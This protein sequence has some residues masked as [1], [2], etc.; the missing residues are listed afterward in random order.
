MVI[1]LPQAMKLPVY[2]AGLPGKV[3][4]FIL[5]PPWSGL[6]DLTPPIPLWRDGAR[7]GQS[8]SENLTEGGDTLFHKKANG[9]SLM[10]SVS[11]ME[12]TY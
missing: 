4:S 6:I 12:E 7:S 9:K 10:F 1:R 3:L 2:R 5:C 11:R 8:L